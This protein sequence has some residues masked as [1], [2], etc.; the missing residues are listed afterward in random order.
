MIREQSSASARDEAKYLKVIIRLLIE[1]Q[2]SI[3][4]MTMNDA[5]TLLYSMHLRPADIGEIVGWSKNSVTGKLANLKK[6]RK[7]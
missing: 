4:K 3:D 6:A 1:Q 7:K 5:I 2:I